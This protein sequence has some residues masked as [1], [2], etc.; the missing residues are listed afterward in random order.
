MP[1]DRFVLILIVVIAAA[2][3]T[4]WIGWLLLVSFGVS[5][6]VGLAFAVPTA[7]VAYVALRIIRDRLENPEE[8]HYDGFEK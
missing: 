6:W 5:G 7:L 1:L 8:D 3:A 2:G 4:I